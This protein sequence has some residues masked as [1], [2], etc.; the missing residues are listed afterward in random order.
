MLKLSKIK[1]LSYWGHGTVP[2]G[3]EIVGTIRR[4]GG[5]EG[6]LIRLSDGNY[7]QGNGGAFRTL[8]KGQVEKLLAAMI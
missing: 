4:D 8:H 5:A 1:P 7:I 2:A 6:A 3:A